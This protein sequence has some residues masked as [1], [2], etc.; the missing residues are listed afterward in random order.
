MIMIIK[1]YFRTDLNS[2]KGLRERNKGSSVLPRF[3]L[4]TVDWFSLGWRHTVTGISPKQ[5][6][7][8]ALML[9][10]IHSE[11]MESWKN[12]NHANRFELLWDR[13]Y[14]KSL[15]STWVIVDFS[16][17]LIAPFLSWDMICLEEKKVL[18]EKGTKNN[19]TGL[20][21]ARRANL[22]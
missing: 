13:V 21:S 1:R 11:N 3:R 6:W 4:K 2:K 10:E 9:K 14:I 7:L 5:A 17:S 15:D 8:Y 22:T 20:T 19:F 16:G 12:I 18:L